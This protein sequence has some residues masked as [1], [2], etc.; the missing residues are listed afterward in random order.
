MPTRV[1]KPL[2]LIGRK[3]REEWRDLAVSPLPERLRLLLERLAQSEKPVVCR[4]DPLK[5]PH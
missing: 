5:R 3:L 4:P 2:D 1:D